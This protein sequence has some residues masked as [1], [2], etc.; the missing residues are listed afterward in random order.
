MKELLILTLGV[1][2]AVLICTSTQVAGQKLHE[3][4]RERWRMLENAPRITESDKPQEVVVT[5]SD[6]Q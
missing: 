2:L 6:P 1:V 3:Q 4:Q 5:A